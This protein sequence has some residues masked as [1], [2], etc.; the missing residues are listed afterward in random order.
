[1]NTVKKGIRGSLLSLEIDQICHYLA[2]HIGKISEDKITADKLTLY[3]KLNTKG[4]TVLLYCTY[5]Q[6]TDRSQEIPITSVSSLHEPL[7]KTNPEVYDAAMLIVNKPARIGRSVMCATCQEILSKTLLTADKTKIYEVTIQTIINHHTT[8]RMVNE[9]TRRVDMGMTAEALEHQLAKQEKA[10]EDAAEDKDDLNINMQNKIG[11]II[12]PELFNAY[13]TVNKMKYLKLINNHN[14]LQKRLPVCEDCYL[15]FTSLNTAA[16]SKESNKLMLID[17]DV[18]LRGTGKLKPEALRV[19]L[20]DTVGKVKDNH[21]GNYR[22]MLLLA[23]VIEEEMKV[24]KFRSEKE[25]LFKK[26]P[27]TKF[28]VDGSKQAFITRLDTEKNELLQKNQLQLLVANNKNLVSILKELT[29]KTSELKKVNQPA[30]PYGLVA[31]HAKNKPTAIPPVSSSKETKSVSL[32]PTHRKFNSMS[33]SDKFRLMTFK[34]TL[35]EEASTQPTQGS[36][37]RLKDSHPRN[38]RLNSFS[39]GVTNYQMVGFEWTDKSTATREGSTRSVGGSRP[40]SKVFR[41]SNDQLFLMYHKKKG[42]LN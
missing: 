33:V 11:N 18:K 27:Q 34:P 2:T 20:E 31:I 41:A 22:R 5:L 10:L 23:D 42:S 6:Y 21:I 19:R 35:S 26:K 8:T 28:T 9:G 1:M 7:L 29:D 38:S 25:R 37:F 16:G 40:K 12:P 17:D 3:F 24:Q 36:R 4:E 30:D 15:Y 32:N 14:F 13:P 39:K